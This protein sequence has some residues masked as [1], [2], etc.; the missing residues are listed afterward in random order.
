MQV[1]KFERVEVIVK[2]V[3]VKVGGNVKIGIIGWCFGGGWLLKSFI[4]VGD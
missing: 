4:M 3:I 1:V 2:G